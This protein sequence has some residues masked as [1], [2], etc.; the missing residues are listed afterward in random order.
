MQNIIDLPTPEPPAPQPRP[1]AELQAD[2][3]ADITIRAKACFEQMVATHNDLM[4]RFWNNPL[5]LTPQ[6]V[7]DGIGVAAASLFLFGGKLATLCNEVKPGSC[8]KVP[9]NNF[10]IN[11]D[12][13]VT[14]LD[15]P[16]TPPQP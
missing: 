8:P 5:G 9:T 4:D 10:T 11:P 1:L 2:A 16:Y 14:I 6:Q 15:E 3:V 12:G 7:A 13:T